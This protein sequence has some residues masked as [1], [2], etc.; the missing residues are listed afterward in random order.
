MRFLIFIP[1]DQLPNEQKLVTVGL[2][3]LVR[4]ASS[5]AT[6]AGPDGKPGVV[7]S[8]PTADPR[9]VV[10]YLPDQQEWIPAVTRDDQAAGRYWVGFS[11]ASPPTAKDLARTSQFEGSRVVL[12]DGSEWLLPAAGRLPQDAKLDP[13]GVWAFEIQQRFQKH[14]D[15]SCAWFWDLAVKA[16]EGDSISL[17]GESVEYLIRALTLNYMLTPEVASHLKL[18]N[19]QNMIPA[20]Q[21][22]VDGIR[23]AEEADQKKTADTPPVT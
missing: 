15:D 11:K 8:W 21:A 5:M 16:S 20:L 18:F 10:G 14:W 2:P 22:T 1:G 12:G 6:G 23:I 4:G 19:S 9:T 3:H 7:F 17:S 13:D